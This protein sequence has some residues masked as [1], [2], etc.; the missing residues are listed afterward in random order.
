MKAV[1]LNSVLRLNFGK[2]AA[3]R[4]LHPGEL[5]CLFVQVS[6][7]ALFADTATLG[8]DGSP[9]E[10]SLRRRLDNHDLLSAEKSNQVAFRAP[11]VQDQCRTLLYF[12]P[13]STSYEVPKTLGGLYTSGFYVRDS[14][15]VRAVSVSASCKPASSV[16]LH[17][18]V[19]AG[20]ESSPENVVEILIDDGSAG[21]KVAIRLFDPQ[22]Y[23]REEAGSLSS[24][25]T[26]SRTRFAS[27]RRSKRTTY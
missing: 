3:R 19:A 5:V 7:E 2:T 21:K 12:E 14:R 11:V 25:L 20:V 8:N 26:K 22:T 10:T 18:F 16:G 1:F 27:F 17:S 24:R 13:F 9:G 6:G 23:R 4:D 15:A